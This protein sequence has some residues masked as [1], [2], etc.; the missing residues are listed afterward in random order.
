MQVSFNVRA[1]VFVRAFARCSESIACP[2][3][4]CAA[5]EKHVLQDVVLITWFSHFL[6]SMCVN[7]ADNSHPLSTEDAVQAEAPS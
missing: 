7:A 1:C 3:I 4:A 2:N 6:S 5:L